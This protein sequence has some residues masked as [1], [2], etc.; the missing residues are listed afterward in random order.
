MLISDFNLPLINAF[1]MKLIYKSY[2]VQF[3]LLIIVFGQV[4]CNKDF[5]N[6]QPLAQLSQATFWNSSS[7]ALLALTGIYQGSD[8]GDASYTNDDLILGSDTDDS[9]YKNGAVGLIYSGYFQASDAQVV[10]AVWTRAYKAIYRANYFLENIDKVQMDAT[11]K[12]Q[13]IAEARFLRA[14][15]YFYMSVLYGGVP[16]VTKTLT[17]AEANSQTRN[18]LKEVQDYAISECTAAAADLPAARPDGEKGRI[19]KGAALGIAGRL[20]MIQQKWPEAAAVYKQ[21]ID[22]NTY[23]LDPRYK[24]IFEEAGEGSKEIL[25]SVNCVASLYGNTHNQ[26]NYHPDFYGGYQED[27]IYQGL[28]DAYECTDGLPIGESPL[29]D[30][31]HP[32][33]H[34]DPRMYA[35]IFLPGY[36]VFRGKLFPADPAST[37]IA[38]L[39]GATRYGWKKF[40]TETYAGDNGSS[41]D[42]IILMRYAEVLLGYLESTLESGGAITQSLLDAIINKV[43]GRSA[44][45]MPAVTETDPDKLRALVQ[46]EDRVEI[47]T[48]GLIRY[49]SIRRW[50]IYQQVIN[51]VFYGMK[52]TDDPANYTDYKVAKTGPYAG[53][54]ISLDKTGTVKQGWDLIPI[55]QSERD[56]NSA[57]TQNPDY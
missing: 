21:I 10:G 12:A 43:R 15:E 17:I 11:L 50:G 44:V 4:G 52:L 38:T 14:Y 41:G 24:E 36:T 9:G 39:I 31:Q 46:N 56:I 6:Q 5:L 16:L 55:P 1:I 13:Y 7:D 26:R 23:I 48:E 20:L 45:N 53:H 40:V 18:T 8:V 25:L 3:V 49:M 27:N 29:Y 33:E 47:A 35:T 37:K 34:R 28:V 42:D 57:L 2:F 19:L 51:T 54:L 22:L 30:P 32:F